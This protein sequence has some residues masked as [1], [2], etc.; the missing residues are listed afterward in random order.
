MRPVNLI[1]ADER[2]G[3]ARGGGGAGSGVRVYILLG[4][5]GAALVCVLALVLTSNQVKSKTEE[6]AKVQAEGQGVKQV[7]DALRPYGQFAM[8]QQA[9]EQQ[10]ASLVSTRFDW[11]RALRQLSLAIPSNVWIL[12]LEGTLSPTV[13]VEGGGGSGDIGNMR[14]Q[15]TAPAF[16][17]QG[18]T[19]SH[20][21]VARMMVRMQNLD[22]VT[23]VRFGDSDRKDESTASQAAA[24]QGSAGQQ[25]AQQ[26]TQDCVGSSRVTKFDILV[27]FGN[28]P[29]AAASGAAPAAAGGSPTNATQQLAKAQSAGVQAQ[30]ASSAAASSATSATGGKP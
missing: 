29:S 27:V 17:I 23:A 3:A 25:S 5:L 28:A 9:R 21:S 2:R 4:A 16:A 20:H 22:D 26:D 15:T 24:T 18:C 10:I 1:P 7:A 30:T 14:E 6:L 13:Q 11:E 8:L 12:N 19:F